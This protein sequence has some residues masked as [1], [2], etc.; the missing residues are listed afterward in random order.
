MG[1]DIYLVTSNG[2]VVTDKQDQII[3]NRTLPVD[4][5]QELSELPLP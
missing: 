4:I 5:A 2:A 1:L 3:Y